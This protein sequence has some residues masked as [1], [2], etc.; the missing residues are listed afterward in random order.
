MG[1]S[2]DSYEER[3]RGLLDGGQVGKLTQVHPEM[4]LAIPYFSI[5]HETTP[6]FVAYMPFSAIKPHSKGYRCC[7][8]AFRRGEP[9]RRR[10]SIPYFDA[11]GIAQLE[12]PTWNDGL[13]P[14]SRVTR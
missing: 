9:V 1:N 8:A 6:A 12:S 11:S 2:S 10:D 14:A 5:S 4:V 3:G 13:K 7:P